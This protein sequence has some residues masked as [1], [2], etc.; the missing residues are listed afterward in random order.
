[1]LHY[2]APSREV[3]LEAARRAG[4]VSDRVVEMVEGH[5]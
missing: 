4:V 5:G 1:V 3:A 2:D